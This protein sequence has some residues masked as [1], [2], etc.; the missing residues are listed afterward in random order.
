MG[1]FSRRF[2]NPALFDMN[3]Q[4]FTKQRLGTS[5]AVQLTRDE[6]IVMDM[7][8]IAHE[9]PGAHLQGAP[10]SVDV[11]FAPCLFVVRPKKSDFPNLRQGRER[12]ETPC[13]AAIDRHVIKKVIKRVTRCPLRPATTSGRRLLPEALTK[14]MGRSWH[15][16]SRCERRNFHWRGS[17]STNPWAH[18]VAALKP[19]ARTAQGSGP[20]ALLES[21]QELR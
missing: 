18:R 9:K 14:S 16:S 5:C 3:D 13:V 19:A 15:P 17:W 2:T 4:K 12:A 21:T 20:S 1:I 7:Q 8:Q 6:R 10:C 11:T